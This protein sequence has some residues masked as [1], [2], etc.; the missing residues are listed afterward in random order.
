ML[1]RSW[2]KALEVTGLEVV[3]EFVERIVVHP[4]HLIAGRFDRLVYDTC[5]KKLRVLDLKTGSSAMNYP[6]AVACQL[7]LYAQAPLMAELDG[8]GGATEKFRRM[9]EV[10]L[11][12]GLV[13]HMPS[14][15]EAV[16]YEVDIAAGWQTVCKV[17]LPTIE[18]RKRKA[19]DLV[20]VA[21]EATVD[22]S[23]V[24]P[25]LRSYVLRRLQWLRENHPAALEV[26][27]RRWPAD[28][29]TLKQ[30]DAH[31]EEQLDAILAL[32]T[33]AEAQHR[34]PFFDEDDPRRSETTNQPP[35]RS[36]A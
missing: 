21:G 8:D 26:V 7:A 17:I 29:P 3:P 32:L 23:L 31:S 14:E 30:S 1:F 6:H 12:V 9:P 16:V 19:A 22:T 35:A 25:L 10:D 15:T 34:I 27:A 36:T 13:V 5:A 33:S 20:N 4:P 18:W 11:D 24:V 28:M 2:R